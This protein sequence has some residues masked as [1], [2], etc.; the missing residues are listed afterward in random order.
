MREKQF[1]RRLIGFNA[2]LVL[3]FG[4][5]AWLPQMASAE[6][7]MRL[8]VKVGI[9][10]DY[11]Q[12][13][14]VP[15]RV[16]VTNTGPDAEGE[17]I[18]ATDNAGWD[19]YGAAYYQP[20]SVAQGATKQVTIAVPG[21]SIRSNTTVS[22]VQDGNTVARVPVKGRSYDENVLLV[23]VLAADANTANFLGVIN[24]N[25]LGREVRVLP[26]KEDQV[27][28][29]GN[30]LHMIDML[31]LNNFALDTLTT[32]QIEAIREWTKTG[33]MLVVAGGAQYAKTV[34]P[35]K[36]LSPVEVTSVT[37]VQQLSDLK[38]EDKQVEL[39]EPFTVS[40]AE[41]RAGRVLYSE[42][43]IPLLVSGTYGQGKVLYVAYDLAAKPLASWS[44]NAVF[45]QEALAR[46][47]GSS[48]NSGD[49]VYLQDDV[50]PLSN[51]SERMP[52]MKLPEVGWF[53]LLFGIYAL[54]AG[55]LL[56]YILRVLRKTSYLWAVVPLLA[57]ITGVGMFSFGTM[58]RGTSVLVHQTGLVELLPESQARVKAVTAMFV[59]TSGDYRLTVHGSGMTQP[60]QED[61]YNSGLP[62]SL[63]RLDE[64][65][66]EI[67]FRNVEFWSM[68][69]AATSQIV[70]DAGEFASD[71]TYANG[72][73]QGTVTNNT[74]YALRDVRVV[75]GMQVQEIAE[76][77]PG[78]TVEVQL[79]FQPNSQSSSNMPYRVVS[80]LVPQNSQNVNYDVER[81]PIIVQMLER[82]LYGSG[83]V[84]KVMITGWT[85]QPVVDVSVGDKSVQ[86]DG[87]AL[88]VSPLE[89]KPSASDMTL[90]P[91][92]YFEAVQS[93]STAD[94]HRTDNGYYMAA[95]EI[96]FDI[97]VTV[98]D[99]R[100][101]VGNLYLYTWSEDSTSFGKQVYN[102]QKQDFEA[103]D[104]VFANGVLP[105]ERAASYLSPEGV[106]RIKFAHTQPGER[107]I[108][109]PSVMV[110]GKVM[111]P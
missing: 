98:D 73:L 70:S 74:K 56:F 57:V 109:I 2:C 3:L 77:A 9:N 62:T 55:P 31:V 87:I 102:W 86:P 26:M 33:G 80:R 81:E 21:E 58:Q 79:S 82:T 1:A 90:Y 41:V 59:P 49:G 19:K 88:V 6:T 85:D 10:G 16:S 43:D 104:D 76:M 4:L 83:W 103:Y 15:I 99:Q 54:V 18:V 63:V 47:F 25:A 78:S 53:A 20:V 93:G 8:D 89:V 75:S 12:S 100:L 68:R 95:G 38:T 110:E 108:G 23:G 28:T 101:E 92:S 39:Q 29:A 22:F 34:G 11:K 96:T 5:V 27:P 71:L 13:K 69:K 45:W 51:A 48:L 24:Q 107:H 60:N 35:L 94:L 36:D 32:Q 67:Q 106:L 84:G 40:Q 61:R 72:T 7:A 97:D 52:A 50:W 66:A 105:G 111:T 46:A 65:Q 91:A 44:G 14:L 64:E 37:S 17:L 42:G 30:Q